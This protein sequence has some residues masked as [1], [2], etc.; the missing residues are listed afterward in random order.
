LI[1]MELVGNA[2]RHAPGEVEVVFEPRP[3]GPVLH[4]LD[5][6]PGFEHQGG[7]ALADP[8]AESGRGLFLIAHHC[9]EFQV[10]R[11]PG[12]GSAA[13]VVL[14]LGREC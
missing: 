5:A 7:R 2:V 8:L 14:G 4:V 6:G 11:R 9:V 12:G 3:G 10:K 1:F 13:R